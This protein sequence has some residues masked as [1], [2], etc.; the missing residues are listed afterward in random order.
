MLLYLCLS[1]IGVLFLM[2]LLAYAR[3]EVAEMQKV[4]FP[5]SRYFSVSTI[6]ILF[7]SYVLARAP[8]YYQKDKL[9]KMGRALGI[10]LL[11]SLLF[12]ISQVL[13][14]NELAQNGI[15][16]KGKPLGSYLYLITA[17]HALHLAAGMAFL[18][19]VY[20]QALTASK[21][22]I[23]TLFYIRDPY[24]KLQLDLL[25]TYWHFLTGLWLCLF[26]VF[27]FLN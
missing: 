22:A 25:T 26:L 15:F 9:N 23:R 17:L 14:W 16:F 6:L 8:K 10:T 3:T 2:L 21:D 18:I 11:I 20:L 7:S 5:F 27:L 12:V 13:G 1:G 4:H 19:F 24:R